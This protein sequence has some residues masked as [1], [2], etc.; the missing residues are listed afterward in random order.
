M[1]SRRHT[2]RE[3]ATAHKLE[4][5]GQEIGRQRLLIQAIRSDNVGLHDVVKEL[6]SQVARSARDQLTR[7]QRRDLVVTL[8]QLFSTG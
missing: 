8:A 6:R 3:I 7:E 5:L 2:P 1:P 4:E